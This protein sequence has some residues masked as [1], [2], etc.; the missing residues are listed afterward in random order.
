MNSMKRQED[1]TLKDEPLRSVGVL[2][3]SRELA[4]E[5]MKGLNG[6]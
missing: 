6:T 4:T 1:V 2:G 3:K 5:R